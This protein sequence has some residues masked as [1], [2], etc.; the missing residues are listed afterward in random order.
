LSAPEAVPEEIAAHLRVILFAMAA[1]LCLLAAMIVFFYAR[2]AGVVPDAAH[3][4]LDNTITMVAM[5]F[6]AATIVV[7]EAVWRGVLRG[8]KG[9]LAQRVETAF[10][11]R[12]ALREGAALL[13]LVAALLCA[14]SGVLRLYPAYW[15]N[16]APFGLFLV[17]A[18]LHWPT[19]ENLAAETGEILPK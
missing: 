11:V 6:A 4:R 13:G 14:L 12:A 3:V 8:A 15:A 10:L 17:F 19:A 7:S 1:G 2:S 18:K 16:F 9:P 5:A